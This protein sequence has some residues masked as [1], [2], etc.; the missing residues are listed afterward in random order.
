M[1]SDEF[2]K[3]CKENDYK[4]EIYIVDEEDNEYDIKEI[5]TIMFGQPHLYIKLKNCGLSKDI[6][7]GFPHGLPECI[8]DGTGKIWTLKVDK[9]SY[10]LYYGDNFGERLYEVDYSGNIKIQQ[11]IESMKNVLKFNKYV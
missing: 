8:M 5:S 4:N 6:S 9:I 1:K 3:W 11:A 2:I 10:K 7:Y